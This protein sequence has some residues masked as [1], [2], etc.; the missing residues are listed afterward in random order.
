MRSILFATLGFCCS[1]SAFAQSGG[2]PR[3]TAGVIGNEIRTQ[4]T[5]SNLGLV[6]SVKT[7]TAIR[8][9][10]DGRQRMGDDVTESLIAEREREKIRLA[11]TRCVIRALTGS[12]GADFKLHNLSS[13]ESRYLRGM[14]Q[15]LRNDYEAF[16]LHPSARAMVQIIDDLKLAATEAEADAD[17]LTIAEYGSQQVKELERRVAFFD[18]GVNP[19]TST[20]TSSGPVEPPANR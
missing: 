18:A 4:C 14:F 15:R 13:D 19:V 12:L 1:L 5:D 10:L 2:Y 3:T 17:Y 9:N 6:G 7:I 8:Q 16:V 20:P 11:K